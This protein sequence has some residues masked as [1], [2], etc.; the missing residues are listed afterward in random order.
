M[1]PVPTTL[2]RLLATSA[3]AVAALGAGATAASAATVTILGEPTVAEGGTAKF[4]YSYTQEG[5]DPAMSFDIEAQG[6]TAGADDLGPAPK[7]TISE[8][9]CPAGFICDSA[10]SFEVPTTDDTL[11]EDDETLVVKATNLNGITAPSGE[12]DTAIVD[13]D[14]APALQLAGGTVIEGN[15]GASNVQGAFR[16]SAPSG[17]EVRVDYGTVSGSAQAGVDFGDRAG[18]VV[19]PA[20][21]TQGAFEI[22]VFGDTEV[23]PDESFRVAAANAVNATLTGGEA[24]ITIRNDDATGPLAPLAT[25]LPTA[26]AAPAGG[27]ALAPQTTPTPKGVVAEDDLGSPVGLSFKGMTFGPKVRVRCDAQERLCRVRLHVRLP[28]RKTMKTVGFRVT[29][30]EA[31][32]ITIAL[33]RRQRRQL[34][35]AGMVSIKAVTVDAAGNRSQTVRSWDL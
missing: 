31:K 34:R 18:T 30:G 22:P 9:A 2:R 27:Q 3:V 1:T 33:S 26:P 4:T 12:A 7:V 15:S 29:G 11:D 5:G 17:R 10:G 23:E 14:E 20:G 28:G 19:I 21:Q 35:R 6:G 24:A 8:D 13:N 16:L 25:D 32:T